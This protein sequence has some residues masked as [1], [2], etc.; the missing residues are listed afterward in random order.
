MLETYEH[1]WHKPLQE[2][3]DDQWEA[4]CDGCGKCCMAKLQDED[5]HKVYYTNVACQQFDTHTCR[6]LDYA[7]RIQKVPDC[8]QLTVENIP[9]FDYLPSTCAYRLRAH[10]KALPVWHPLVSG[11]ADSVHSAGM[12][13]Q[14]KTVTIQQ[15]GPLEHHLY[16]WDDRDDC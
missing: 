7:H 3:T 12:S 14:H 5:T 15:A 11:D 2:L 10:G 8:I 4:L 13:V 16:D 1:W 6:C 9:A